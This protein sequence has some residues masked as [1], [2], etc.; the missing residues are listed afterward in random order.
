MNDYAIRPVALHE[1]GIVAR[2]RM[3]MFQDMGQVPPHLAAPLQE[4]SE[5][6]LSPLL[7]S[8][9]YV[10]WFATDAAGAVIAGAGVHI[11]PQ[12][13]RISLSGDSVAESSAPLVVNVYTEPHWRGRG[14]A[15]ALMER[16]MRWAAEQ[17][18]ERVVLHASDDGRPLYVSLGFTPSNEMRWGPGPGE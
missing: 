15:R 17:D 4:A 8:G 7:A 10:G 16:L 12:L 2:H 11:K 3:R 9:E 18:Y 14:V 1:A 13:P 5:R 6:A